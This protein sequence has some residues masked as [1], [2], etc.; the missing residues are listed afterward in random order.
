V[1]KAV[2]RIVRAVFPASLGSPSMPYVVAGDMEVS[3]GDLRARR[4][5]RGTGLRASPLIR[6][7]PGGGRC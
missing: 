6:A 7:N 3:P 4:D 5:A 1:A 2:W